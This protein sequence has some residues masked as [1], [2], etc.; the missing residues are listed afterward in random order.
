MRPP[1]DRQPQAAGWVESHPPRRCAQIASELRCFERRR[2]RDARRAAKTRAGVRG[3]GMEQDRRNATQR[4]EQR[5]AYPPLLPRT[6]LRAVHWLCRV[7]SSSRSA[8]VPV[9]SDPALCA[10]AR[11][12]TRTDTPGCTARLL[13][14]R[15]Q[16]T[17]A[18][19]RQLVKQSAR[20]LPGA[21]QAAR[22]ARVGRLVTHVLLGRVVVYAQNV[23]LGPRVIAGQR[24]SRR[25]WQST[26]AAFGRK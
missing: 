16:T 4:Q 6:P 20:P 22:A 19:F 24:L 5:R 17:C 12:V 15:Q 23:V 13:T 25:P 11:P 2:Q 9:S 10:W 8:W 3:R 7:S 14:G 21:L 18:A 26:Q 1:Y